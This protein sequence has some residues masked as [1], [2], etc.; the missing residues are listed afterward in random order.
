MKFHG[1][2][3][4]SKTLLLDHLILDKFNKL[5]KFKPLSIHKVSIRMQSN[6]LV[7]I[8]ELHHCFPK[9]IKMYK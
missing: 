8:K 9:L 1:D 7:K 3:L 4:K 2:I 5:I 6:I